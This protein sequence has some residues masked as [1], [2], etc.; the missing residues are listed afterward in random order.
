MGIFRVLF[1]GKLDDGVLVFRKEA[2]KYAVEC[3]TL[4]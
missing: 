3:C 1:G 4:M 2:G